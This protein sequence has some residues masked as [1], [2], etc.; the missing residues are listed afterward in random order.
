MKCDTQ[1]EDDK[2]D[3]I[4]YSVVAID[5]SY[6]WSLKL[7]NDSFLNC[8]N[9]TALNL[10][11]SGIWFIRNSVLVN[12]PLLEVIHLTLFYNNASFP[13]NTFENLL[14]LKSVS[15][16]TGQIR[17]TLEEFDFIMRKLPGTLEELNVSIPGFEGISQRLMTFTKLRKLGLRGYPY[18]LYILANDTF[19]RLK[20][21]PIEEL[22]IR[23]TRI[24]A[25]QPLAFHY[26]PEL[27]ILDMSGTPSLSIADF[28][29]AFIGL[30][31][32]KLERLIL[33]H[34]HGSV[35][36]DI[37]DVAVLNDS[38]CGN[39]ILPHLTDL[40]IDNTKLYSIRS[41]YFKPCFAGLSNLRTLNMSFNFLDAFAVL[42]ELELSSL[43]SL[44]ELDIKFQY[45][46]SF[47]SQTAAVIKVSPNLTYL[48]MSNISCACNNQPLSFYL[49]L[50]TNLR[51]INFQ[52]NFVTNLREFAI[53][54]HNK[55][56]FFEVD[57]SNNN[58]ISFTGS[59][60]VT[61]MHDGLKVNSLLLS[62]NK[63][64]EQLAGER[65]VH[66]F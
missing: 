12:M 59:F 14:H 63:L 24:S 66:V 28:F 21:V 25:I 17:G 29:P 10:S 53:D 43:P 38:F 39:L 57:I 58:M 34:M 44:I 41:S 50:A 51:L 26:L 6:M 3:M 27:K 45:D 31:N 62:G 4:P 9:V 22:T 64:G 37:P 18:Y 60:D 32:T 2:L 36:I 61:I 40:Q 47:G 33:S 7:Q 42:R 48:D 65:G 8:V 11:S 49:Q 13:D 35:I 30:R 56:V 5:F 16:L 55:S 52:N 19:E 46:L 1:L 54:G 15:I 23:S 20:N